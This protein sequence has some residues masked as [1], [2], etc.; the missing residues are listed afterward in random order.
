MANP[1]VLRAL[2]D[3]CERGESSRDLDKE[4]AIA[5]GWLKVHWRAG[6]GNRE[7][8]IGRRDGPFDKVRTI[9]HYTT[10]LDAAVTLAPDDAGITLSRYWRKEPGIWWS[11]HL[12]WGLGTYKRAG[13][14]ARR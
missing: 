5:L 14:S 11:A 4:I 7:S 12:V 10:S 13:R 9:P 2:A 3:R 8:L 6:L 1:S